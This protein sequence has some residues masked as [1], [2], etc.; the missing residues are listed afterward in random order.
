M[1]R[2]FFWKQKKFLGGTWIFLNV[3]GF[4][5]QEIL[6]SDDLFGALLTKLHFA[7][8]EHNLIIFSRSILNFFINFEI[9]KKKFFKENYRRS[10]QKCILRVQ[11]TIWWETGFPQRSVIVFLSLQVSKQKLCGIFGRKIAVRHSKLHFTCTEDHLGWKDTFREENNVFIIWDLDRRTVWLLQTF[12]L[13]CWQNG[14]IRHQNTI[15]NIC[16]NI[17]KFSNQFR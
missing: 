10:C 4:R 17:F 3:F 12:F 13:H 14:N 15:L 1:C 5:V 16:S 7:S 11:M 2:E 8:P 9:W 6:T